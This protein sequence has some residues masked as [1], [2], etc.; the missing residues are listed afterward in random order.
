[1][2]IYLVLFQNLLINAK[3]EQE[4]YDQIKDFIKNKNNHFETISINLFKILNE[5]N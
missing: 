1:M 4:A 2:I 3:N 5:E